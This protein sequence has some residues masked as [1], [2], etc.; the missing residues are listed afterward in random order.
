MGCG[1]GKEGAPSQSSAAGQ[2][3]GGDSNLPKKDVKAGCIGH[4]QFIQ[5][6]VG[7]IQEFYDLDKKKL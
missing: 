5:D 3:S 2:K 6:N 7:K 4:A 1:G